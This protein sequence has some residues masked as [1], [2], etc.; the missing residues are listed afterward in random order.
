[1]L[2]CNAIPQPRYAIRSTCA[3]PRSKLTR[4]LNLLTSS[5]VWPLQARRSSE[6]PYVISDYRIK[7]SGVGQEQRI[8]VEMCTRQPRL[9]VGTRPT[10]PL[11]GQW[12]KRGARVVPVVGSLV[13]I[14]AIR[15][16]NGDLRRHVAINVA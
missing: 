8:P 7:H 12:T 16:G 2:D 1:M 5:T 4:T 6:C 11:G 9:V 13:C 15:L 3:F 14:L 10:V